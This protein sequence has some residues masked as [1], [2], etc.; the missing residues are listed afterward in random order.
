MDYKLQNLRTGESYPLDPDR[1]LIGSA[2]HAAV[3]TGEDSPFLAVLAVRYPTGWVVHGLSDDPTVRFNREPLRTPR[4][5]AVRPADLLDVGEERFRFVPAGGGP[6][7][8]QP[9]AEPAPPCYAYILNPD[10]ME[11][12]RVIDH[13]LLIGRLSVCHVRLPDKRLSRLTALLA[14]HAG[15][16][17]VHNL[18]RNP[19]VARN[20]ELV[21]GYAALADGDELLVGP[22]VVRIELATAS[23]DA[24]LRPSS[25][26][27][28]PGD[29]DDSDSAGT[30]DLAEFR[31]AALKLDR[32][33]KGQ[34]PAPVARE[35][36]GGWLGAQKAKLSR[37]WFDT[38]ETTHARG[39]RTAGRF[40]DAFEI[41]DRAVRAR[42]DGPEL[43]RELYR[44]HDAAGLRD[45]CYRPL[46]QIEKL[47]ESRGAPDPWVLE[48]MARLCERL[49][50]TDPSMFDRA[51]RYWDKLEATT[52]VSYARERAS[53]MATRALRDGGF[54]APASDEA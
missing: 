14:A 25:A 12:C 23:G 27:F 10:G 2:D 54:A 21:S 44:L 4:Q 6:A 30:T 5:V 33:L 53:A 35:G 42:P 46:R 20:R 37:F 16:W 11:E 7:G 17:Y 36:L 51:M 43:L 50:K 47:A 41:L 39:L 8:P 52:G 40:A 32:W 13:D 38:P 18:A 22:L 34:E 26:E 28:T 31:A 1:T 29:F 3:R 15:V 9:P 19:I 45:L 24:A 49:G 48:E